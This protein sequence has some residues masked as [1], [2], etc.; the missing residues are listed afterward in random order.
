MYREQ[1]CILLLAAKSSWLFVTSIQPALQG[2]HW[3]SCSP[4]HR[5]MTS[6]ACNVVYLSLQIIDIVTRHFLASTMH[7]G[8]R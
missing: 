3:M 6:Q 4:V 7:A 5:L 8:S 2:C 1:T